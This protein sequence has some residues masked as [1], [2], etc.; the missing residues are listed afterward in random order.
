MGIFVRRSRFCAVS[1]SFSFSAVKLRCD[2]KHSAI[3]EQERKWPIAMTSNLTSRNPIHIGENMPGKNERWSAW[4]FNILLRMDQKAFRCRMIGWHFW[5]L[6]LKMAV[7]KTQ[8]K[9]C[10]TSGK[11]LTLPVRGYVGEINQFQYLWIGNIVPSAG[12]TSRC[13]V[14]AFSVKL[15]LRILVE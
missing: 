8:G 5:D 13:S 1:L 11:R 4:Q 10:Y 3:A 7:M 12:V 14:E 2:L 15:S 6:F 9:L